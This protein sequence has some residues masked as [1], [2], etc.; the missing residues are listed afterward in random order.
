MYN[1]IE[2]RFKG[3]SMKNRYVFIFDY[4]CDWMIV[5]YKDG[6]EEKYFN[7]AEDD[8]DDSL[9][10]AD[11]FVENGGNRYYYKLPDY[12]YLEGISVFSLEDKPISELSDFLK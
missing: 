5:C 1:P 9:D 10:Y 11:M 7:S 4:E 6:V 2:S 3:G 12:D 8:W